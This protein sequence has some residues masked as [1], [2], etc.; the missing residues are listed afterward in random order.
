MV[1]TDL[2]FIYPLT[3][4]SKSICKNMIYIMYYM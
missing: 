2:I 1:D 4:T 3:M